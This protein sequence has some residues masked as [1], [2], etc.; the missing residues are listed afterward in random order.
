MN[1]FDLLDVNADLGEGFSHDEALLDRVSSASICCGAH[2]GDPATIRR[3]L[4]A[5]CERG[6]VVGAH[7]GHPDREGFGR[8][9]RDLD[10]AG[11]ERLIRDQVADLRR[12]ADEVG[13]SIRFL[14][15]HGSLY[16][17]AQSGGA[18]G[19]G[20]VAAALALGLP[21]LGLPG[22]PLESLAGTEGLEFIAEGFPDRRY[23][24]DGSLTPRGEPGA[25]LHDPDELVANVR[26]LATGGRVRTLCLHGDE[27]G[28]VANADR[29]LAI[30]VALGI[31]VRPFV[32]Q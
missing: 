9:D 2:A 31:D 16:N 7:P 10:A 6:V 24:G 17:Q 27:P 25:V 29:L 3:T 13:V 1:T 21:L 20:V 15:P 5:A 23:R 28:A 14:K 19:R 32:D 8:R 30:L 26:T 4:T 11:V 12:L 18:V 22:S